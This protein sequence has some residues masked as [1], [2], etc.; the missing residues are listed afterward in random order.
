MLD[1]DT[2]I[3]PDGVVDL[4]I[5]YASPYVPVPGLHKHGQRGLGVESSV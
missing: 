4:Q 3:G 5:L 1:Q 2:A